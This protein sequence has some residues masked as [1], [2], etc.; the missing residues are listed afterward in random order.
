[1][2]NCPDD[3]GWVC[4]A[5]CALASNVAALPMCE[6]IQEHYSFHSPFKF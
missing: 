4:C 2:C 5:L 3:K 1:M 6:T